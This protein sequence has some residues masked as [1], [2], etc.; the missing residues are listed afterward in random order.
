MLTRQKRAEMASAIISAM[1]A[2]YE[3]HGES[4]DFADGER[5]LRDDASEDELRTEYDKWVQ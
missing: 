3:E 1:Q 5:H 2:H 4:G